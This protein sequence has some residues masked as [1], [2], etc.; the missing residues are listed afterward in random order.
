M[1]EAYKK[2]LWEEILKRFKAGYFNRE[3]KTKCIEMDPRLQVSDFQFL[4]MVAANIAASAG[5]HLRLVSDR[6]TSDGL[7]YVTRCSRRKELNGQLAPHAG[8]ATRKKALHRT[9]TFG[10]LVL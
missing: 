8:R 5:K 10:M 2:K 3:L 6:G 1:G 9:T 7:R 4:S